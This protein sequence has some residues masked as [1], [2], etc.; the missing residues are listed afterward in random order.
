MI[1]LEPKLQL[2]NYLEIVKV[3]SQPLDFWQAAKTEQSLYYNVNK[4]CGL[5]SNAD[6]NLN[7]KSIIAQIK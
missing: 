3:Y 2:M 5:I 6:K 1:E 4:N 7:A